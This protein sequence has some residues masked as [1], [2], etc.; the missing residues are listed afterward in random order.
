[1]P[2]AALDRLPEDEEEPFWEE[3]FRRHLVGRVVESL[4][5]EFP[6]KVWRAFLA[7][8]MDGKP[9]SRVAAE[10]DINIWSVYSAKVRVLEHLTQEFPEL[11]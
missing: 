7:H 8:V 6:P 4:R 1:V 11:V 2:N 9:A 10:M 3:E 5:A